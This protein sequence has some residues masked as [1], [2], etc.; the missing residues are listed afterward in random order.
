[1]SLPESVGLEIVAQEELKATAGPV[2]AAEHR[3]V[4]R[5]IRSERAATRRSLVS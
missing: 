5:R 2:P 3:A 4:G 1:M